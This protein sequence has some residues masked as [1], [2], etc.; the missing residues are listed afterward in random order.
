MLTSTAKYLF[1]FPLM[2]CVNKKRQKVIKRVAQKNYIKKKKKKKKLLINYQ[3]KNCNKLKKFCKKLQ[4][5]IVNG[6][7]TVLL[8]QPISY[9]LSTILN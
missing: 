2:G 6:H 7:F 9:Y 4:K 5:V 3:K 8:T 1:R